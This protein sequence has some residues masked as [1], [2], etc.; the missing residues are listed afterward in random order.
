[1]PE[2]FGSAI[3]LNDAVIKRLIPDADGQ[4][5][6]PCLKEVMVCSVYVHNEELLAFLRAR[7]QSEHLGVTRLQRAVF[8][9][10]VWGRLVDI[11][12][13]MTPFDAK[14]LLPEHVP[15]LQDAHRY[16]FD[17]TIWQKGWADY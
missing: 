16:E 12:T 2:V 1:V 4:C 10:I 5:L 9:F 7:T 6:C 8:S 14:G 3:V 17:E 11:K 13:D 15:Q